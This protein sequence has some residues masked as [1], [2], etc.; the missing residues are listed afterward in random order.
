MGWMILRG[1]MF[2]IVFCR[3]L[4]NM[5]SATKILKG[6]DIRMFDG[7]SGI[8][9]ECLRRHLRQLE[10]ATK[11]KVGKNNADLA[12]HSRKLAFVIYF[13]DGGKI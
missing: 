3:M 8:I 2:F 10:K 12:A 9:I 1:W 4:T 11:T 5:N 6:S 7:N 13:E